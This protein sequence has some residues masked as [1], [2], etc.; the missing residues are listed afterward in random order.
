MDL[1]TFR[2]AHPGLFSQAFEAGVA[3]ATARHLEHLA[4]ASA[5][6]AQVLAE[7]AIRHGAS[8]ADYLPKYRE[9][10]SRSDDTSAALER[11][12][13]QLDSP[14][15]AARHPVALGVVAPGGP[16]ASGP[17]DLGDLFAE[18]LPGATP[19]PP[20]AYPRAAAPVAIRDLGDLFAESLPPP[21]AAA[22]P[23]A[24]ATVAEPDLADR[25]ADD[26]PRA[27]ARA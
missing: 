1:S 22:T 24:R 6:G 8:V 19:P 13:G 21:R 25:F 2:A 20:P 17:R 14:A 5:A 12:I 26:L 16:A 7:R 27:G 15:G 4:L 9:H 10:A 23:P 11:A 18:S 3:E